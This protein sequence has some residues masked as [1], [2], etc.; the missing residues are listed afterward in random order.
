MI[1]HPEMARMPIYS[2]LSRLTEEALIAR[3]CGDDVGRQLAM[4]NH[5]NIIRNEQVIPNPS[6][7]ERMLAGR[8]AVCGLAAY[9]AD[10]FYEQHAAEINA[11]ECES[12]EKRRNR[13]HKRF[14]VSVKTL[15]DVRKRALP[16]L[17]NAN[18]VTVKPSQKKTSTSGSAKATSSCPGGVKNGSNRV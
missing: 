10:L 2:D 14:L 3:V 7:V 1:K 6:P 13:T 5:I 11:L 8:I 12:F 15:D 4:H 9:E 18:Q 17:I 16:V